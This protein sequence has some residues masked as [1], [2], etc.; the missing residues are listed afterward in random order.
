MTTR[1]S[2]ASFIKQ[3]CIMKYNQAT[4]KK[5]KENY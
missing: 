4:Y 1:N 3:I 5:K 2:K